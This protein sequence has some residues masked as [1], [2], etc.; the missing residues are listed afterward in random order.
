MNN[1]NTALIFRF[2]EAFQK[3]DAESMSD[4]YASDAIFSDPAFGELRGSEIGDMW[5][6]LT[7]RVEDFSLT[8]EIVYASELEAHVRWSPQYVFPATGRLIVN[9]IF[10]TFT[11]SNGRISTHRDVFNLWRWC[12]QALGLKGALLGWSPIMQRA[13]AKQAKARLLQ[14][15]MASGHDVRHSGVPERSGDRD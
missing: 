10:A 8:F 4:C 13:V 9:H 2:Y 7:S 5:R 12:W 1:K 11:F 14:F 6:M 15:R 3:L